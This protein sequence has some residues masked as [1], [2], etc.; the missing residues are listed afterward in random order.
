MSAIEKPKARLRQP[1]KPAVEDVEAAE[2]TERLRIE[3]VCL[4]VLSIIAS[5]VVLRYAQGILMPFVLA[6]LIFYALDPIVSWFCRLGVPR[7]AASRARR[8]LRGP[9]NESQRP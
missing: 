5:V 9:G 6:L 3:T 1:R 7:V 4:V 8:A 2:K